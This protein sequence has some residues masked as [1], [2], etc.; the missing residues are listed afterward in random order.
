MRVF[1]ALPLSS[2]AQGKMQEIIRPL[3]KQLNDLCWAPSKNW[4]VTLRF[5]GHIKAGEREMLIRKVS[6]VARGIKKFEIKIR[7]I[8]KFPNMDSRIIAAY[9]QPDS[10]LNQLFLKLNSGEARE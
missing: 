8:D 4:H 9:V 5:V 3:K 6:E 7:K 10:F 2:E 1:V